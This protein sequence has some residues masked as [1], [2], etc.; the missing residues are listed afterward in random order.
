MQPTA[1]TQFAFPV[2]AISSTTSHGAEQIRV[3]F[4]DL[5][6]ALRSNIGATSGSR[7]NRNN[8]TVF[9]AK[10][11]GSSS[12]FNL[13]VSFASTRGMMMEESDRI[14]NARDLKSVVRDVCS[15]RDIVVHC[16][17]CKVVHCDICKVVPRDV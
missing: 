1:T 13:D 14:R 2:R 16:D 7:I 6:D 5:L 12:M 3:D 17:I 9:E 4:N 10:S 11:Q 8:N 15:V